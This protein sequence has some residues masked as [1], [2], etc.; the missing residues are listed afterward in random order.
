VSHDRSEWPHEH[1]VEIS[2]NVCLTP[3][4]H[5]GDPNVVGPDGAIAGG[6][7]QHVAGFLICHDRVRDEREP[8]KR[9]MPDGTP[10]WCVSDEAPHEGWIHAPV[11]ESLR[12][13]MDLRCVGS[14][15]VD[16]HFAGERPIWTMSGSLEGGDLTLSPSVLCSDGFHGFVRDGKWV[17]A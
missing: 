5:G 7:D 3:T 8:A 12:A 4:V 14:V 10:C 17:S 13:W 11:C 9:T 16:P 6:P 15:N 1:C 2:A